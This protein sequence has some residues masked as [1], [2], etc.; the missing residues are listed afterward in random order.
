MSNA[1]NIKLLGSHRAWYRRRGARN[2]HPRDDLRNCELL[3]V[4]DTIRKILETLSS[5]LSW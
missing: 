4:G 5:E 1:L 2:R 3:A